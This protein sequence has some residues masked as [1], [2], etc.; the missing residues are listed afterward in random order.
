LY[1]TVQELHARIADQ[2]TTKQLNQIERVDMDVLKEHKPGRLKL[3]E[4]S[5]DLGCVTLQS[6]NR[7]DQIFFIIWGEKK[8]IGRR[9]KIQC[10]KACGCRQAK[11]KTTITRK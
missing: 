7:S 11:N 2:A 9:M 6:S 10:E 4:K 3:P 5:T 1:E 8:R